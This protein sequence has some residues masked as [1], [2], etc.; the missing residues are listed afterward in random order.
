M[1][2][3]L[4][5]WLWR[6]DYMASPGSRAALRNNLKPSE[7]MQRNF[8]ITT[9]GLEDP[10]VLRYVIDKLGVERVMWA[11]DYPFQQTPASV[12]FLESAPLSEAE[13]EQISHRNAERIFRIAT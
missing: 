11:I 13:R 8:S 9:S 12:A 6:L 3:A 5:F 10:L 2:E 7:Y 1:G 4:P